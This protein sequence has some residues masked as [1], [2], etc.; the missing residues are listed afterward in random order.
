MGAAG[1]IDTTNR[2]IGNDKRQE[3]EG[4]PSLRQETNKVLVLLEGRCDKDKDPGNEF[5]LR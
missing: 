4:L 1:G 5:M 2:V 3:P